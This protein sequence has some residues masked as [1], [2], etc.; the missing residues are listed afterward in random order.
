MNEIIKNVITSGRYEL[1]DMLKKIDTIWLQGNLT[2]EQ[3]T[4]LVNLARN[5][6]D[7]ENSYASIQ[8]QIN[9]LYANYIELAARILILENGGNTAP[10]D[11]EAYP[12]FVQPTGAHDAY[13]AGDQITYNGQRYIC[14]MNGC[15]W[16][17]DTYPAGWTLVENEE[18]GN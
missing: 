7:P 10:I 17:P 2:D 13:K 5:N 12:E 8:N 9:V 18:G 14:Q 16:D 3:R 1:A 11:P 4:E 6:A 15:V